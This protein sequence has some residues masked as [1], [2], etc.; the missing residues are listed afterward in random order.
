MIEQRTAWLDAVNYRIA[1]ASFIE[2]DACLTRRKANIKAFP[3][4][5]KAFG[6]NGICRTIQHPI[7]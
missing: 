2:N 1:I 6:I 4:I 3:G 7:Q 5:P